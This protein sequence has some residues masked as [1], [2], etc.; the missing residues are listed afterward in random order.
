MGF[1]VDELSPSLEGEAICKES[2]IGLN[3]IGCHREGE[4]S[5]W[6]LK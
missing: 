5:I 4:A 3:D 1:R 6:E 2:I